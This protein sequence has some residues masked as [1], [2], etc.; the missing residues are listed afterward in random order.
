MTPELASVE[1][2][3]RKHG[4]RLRLRVKPGGRR[5][6]LVGPY[7]GALKLEVQ[8]PPDRGKA[9]AAVIALLAR[10]LDVPRSAVVLVGGTTSQ[11]KIVEIQGID[12]EALCK[13][14]LG[15]GVRASS[16]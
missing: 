16:T 9:N 8:A 14:L 10:L 1:I 4:A 13:R 12:A 15:R 7:G 5:D 2:V 11:D 3:R 6:R